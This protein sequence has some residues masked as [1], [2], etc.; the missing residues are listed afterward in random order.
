M[1]DESNKKIRS[2]FAFLAVSFLANLFLT[3]GQ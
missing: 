1:H 3:D 2:Y